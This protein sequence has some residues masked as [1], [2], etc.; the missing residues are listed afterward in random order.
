[1]STERLTSTSYLV[2]GL[3]AREGPLTRYALE[4]HVAATLGNFWS[5][6]HT[7][8]ASGG[9]ISRRPRCPATTARRPVRHPLL[10][11][12]AAVAIGPAGPRP[13]PGR[14]RIR[15]PTAV[16]PG[17]GRARPAARGRPLRGGLHNARLG[18]GRRCRRAADAAGGHRLLCVGCRLYFLRWW[19]P[20]V[21][22]RIARRT[23]IP[24]L[25][26]RY[27]GSMR[28]DGGLLGDRLERPDGEADR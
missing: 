27:R 25:N 17:A 7:L 14:T 1:M 10:G 22:D 13:G 9:R 6:P 16:R 4:R 28:R 5:F 2:L 23:T 21:F 11:P 8:L 20:S 3:L 18:P 12:R 19:I 26:R 24:I 15:V